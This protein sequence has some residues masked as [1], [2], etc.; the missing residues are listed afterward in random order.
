M[1]VKDI[2]M[3][4]LDVYKSEIQ[5]EVFFS[6]NKMGQHVEFNDFKSAITMTGAQYVVKR[7]I[8]SSY[9]DK[10][11]NNLYVSYDYQI[12]DIE[13]HE[14]TIKINNIECVKITG[15]D[16]TTSYPR[17]VI[18]CK[19]IDENQILHNKHFTSPSYNTAFEELFIYMRK[20]STYGTIQQFHEEE[21]KINLLKE[22][23]ILQQKNELL[24]KIVNEEFK[25]IEVRLDSEHK[26]LDT[27]LKIILESM[28]KFQSFYPSEKED[29]HKLGFFKG[30]FNQRLKM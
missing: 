1:K 5:K 15:S 7:I 24:E 12:F 29:Q 8:S 13:S 25:K 23:K 28:K 11:W 22:I 4:K 6:I 16:D 18:S 26:Q 20:L 14:T 10:E 27:T 9:T 19:I 21:E 3:T 17:N 2:R 30:L